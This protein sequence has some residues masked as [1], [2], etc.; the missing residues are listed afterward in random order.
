MNIFRHLF[1]YKFLSN[2]RVSKTDFTPAEILKN[3]ALLA[4]YAGFASGMYLFTEKVIILLHEDYRIG[5]FF[6][7]RFAAIILFMV[8]LTVSAGNIL[9]GFATFYRSREVNFLLSKPVSFR[10]V[11]LIKFIDNFFY[12]SG[13]L[14]L[15]ICAALLAYGNYFKQ[16]F[17][18]YLTVLGGLILPF[19]L[20]AGILGVLILFLIVRIAEA[21]GP[22]ITI[23][24]IAAGYIAVT[25]IFFK[26]NDP[27]EL[28]AQAS[29][30]EARLSL[31]L[32]ALDSPYIKIFP[33]IW[34]ADA[35]YWIQRDL[36]N[37]AASY[38]VIVI[39]LTAAFFIALIL[40][41]EKYFYRSY[42]TVAELSAGKKNTTVSIP[43][44]KPAD[45]YTSPKTGSLFRKEY[46]LFLREPVQVL[47]LA[48]LIFLIILF[49]GSIGGRPF[50]MFLSYDP[51][52]QTTVYLVFFLFIQFMI[53]TLALR[54]IF[55]HLSLEGETLWRLRSAPVKIY[56]YAG[57][58][59]AVLIT[60]ILLL[61]L[62]LTHFANRRFEGELYY[63][64]LA[65]TIITAFTVAAI[66]F[67]MGG[68][69]PQFKEKNPIRISSSSGA[70]ISFL[71][72][73]GYIMLELL[74]LA[75]NI[76]HYFQTQGPG[77][78]IFNQAVIL[79]T[80]GIFLFVSVTLSA[81]GI[82]AGLRAYRRDIVV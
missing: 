24:I 61:S 11:F 50:R 38:I 69:F 29:Y 62:A 57:S 48:L 27:V 56:R 51:G 44:W 74:L 31:Y 68:L 14:F 67:G 46:L 49:T 18:F 78:G 39:S 73:M 64:S 21:I 28:V 36:H 77:G 55:P 53:V 59:F 1:F 17:G 40:I 6:F 2:I 16:S 80:T 47:H 60:G 7:H 25:A 12:S 19:L 75:P 41:A 81:A 54:F 66:N 8:F 5:L 79:N 42:Q 15:I 3:I 22:K 33:G 52:T 10:Q 13:T 37:L 70:S 30:I 58:K 72:S 63:F 76:R 35:L 23:G 20:L 9:V 71:I 32:T 45:S 82:I 34:V 43:V 4:V 26:L 65:A